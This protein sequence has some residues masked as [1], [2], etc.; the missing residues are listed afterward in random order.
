MLMIYRTLFGSKNFW[1]VDKPADPFDGWDM[2]EILNTKC[3][4]A[5]GDTYGKL[6]HFLKRLF[7]QFRHQLSLHDVK[8][9]VLNLKAPELKWVIGNERFSRI[10]VGNTELWKQTVVDISQATNIHDGGSEIKLTLSIFCPLLEERVDN[11][12]ATL[13]THFLYAVED[14]FEGQLDEEA[15]SAYDKFLEHKPP[16]PF[17][18]PLNIGDPWFVQLLKS[19]IHFFDVEKFFEK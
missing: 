19:L 6:Y 16:E 14:E 7:A 1:N 5:R 8:F 2:R 13:V 11:P 15:D 17:N 3:G 18:N 4:P 9:K 12:H 10:E